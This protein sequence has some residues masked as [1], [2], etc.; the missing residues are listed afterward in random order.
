M[1][2]I[3]HRPPSSP[4]IQ[5][6]SLSAPPTPGQTTSFIPRKLFLQLLAGT[7][8]IFILT[9][10]FWKSSRFF[11]SFTKDRVL[12][13]GNT[14][15][16]RYAKTWY[17]W[18]SF[19]R[20]EANKQFMRKS[21]AKLGIRTTWESSRT[22][23]GWVRGD[24]RQKQLG[25][26]QERSQQWLPRRATR[27]GVEAN[28]A[29][30]CPARPSSRNPATNSGCET[31]FLPFAT[32]ALPPSEVPVPPAT[33]LHELIYRDRPSQEGPHRTSSAGNSTV[34]QL[35]RVGISEVSR[36]NSSL[37]VIP[38]DRKR[39]MSISQFPLT[40]SS[41]RVPLTPI[42]YRK[43]APPSFS[44]PCLSQTGNAPIQPRPSPNMATN[45]DNQESLIPAPDPFRIFRCSRRY[46][47]WSAQM[48]MQTLKCLGYSTHTLPMGPPG[49]P[50]SALLGNYSMDR[51]KYE[52]A[53]QNYKIVRLTSS[54]GISDLFL[55]G[56]AQ[57]DRP[58]RPRSVHDERAR[59]QPS[60]WHT[61]PS[62]RSH[63]TPIR[64]PSPLTCYEAIA[65][66]RPT[67][68]TYAETMGKRS[69]PRTRKRPVIDSAPEYI[70]PIRDWSNW[71]VRLLDNLDRR[72]GWVSNQLTPG[73]RPF[74]FALLA[75][76]WL[77]RETW[78]VYDPISRVPIDMRR[79]W[80]DPR[81]NVPYP[82]PSGASKRR[83]P[84]PHRRPA[85]T[86]KINSWRLAMNRYRRRSGL[87]DLIRKIEIYGSSVEEP[88]DGQ[89]DPAS[90]ILR[91]PPEGFQLSARQRQTYY[92]GGAGWQE[93]LS[94]WQKIRRGYRVRKAIYEGRV[95]R[96]RAKEIAHGITRYCQQAAANLF[97]PNES[98][99]REE[100]EEL[101]T[102]E[103]FQVA[104]YE[105]VL[106]PFLAPSFFI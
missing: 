19:P 17:G 41:A 38:Y 53:R 47:I 88:P 57:Q 59:V 75:N 101:S 82:A 55:G 72:L 97:P 78:I 68:F 32:G 71:E 49:S 93:K 25:T 43:S 44:M 48:G 46:Q 40:R 3:P 31:A 73:Q 56:G 8:G 23:F 103:P 67:S 20:H 22:D 29:I 6:P 98:N 18:V 96:T 2:P 83:Y 70:I 26:D 94:D 80:G 69:K 9:V 65:T 89:I 42:Y 27:H 1:A 66:D 102:E 79:H 14:T 54:S 64:R 52:R 50:G 84:K 4:L 105:A 60:K 90:W 12:R 30:R 76:H 45:L 106:Y 24:P 10:L 87:K 13:P 63:P 104:G 91:K 39:F 5:R 11:R 37:E 51:T 61:M 35:R 100:N 34:Q 28:E 15:T 21:M 36:S 62:F 81:F 74:H 99:N 58:R 77:N 86:P 85:N 7:V 33:P 92:E 95:N 16:A